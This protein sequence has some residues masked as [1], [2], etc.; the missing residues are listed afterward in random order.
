MAIINGGHIGYPQYCKNVLVATTLALRPLTLSELAILANLPPD[1]PRTITEDCGSFLIIRGE[2]VYLI[3]QLAKDYLEANFKSRLQPAGVAQ[4]HVDISRRSINAMSSRLVKNVYALPLGFKPKDIRPPDPDRLAPIRY[5]C[6]FWA[7]HLYS[8][9][10]ESPECK[11]E[12]MDDGR[13][14]MFLK[15]RFLR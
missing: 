5:S 2:I 15:E 10:S 12:L 7:D 4:G 3:H 13:V 11:I 9:N 6:V 1:M 14:F 8:L